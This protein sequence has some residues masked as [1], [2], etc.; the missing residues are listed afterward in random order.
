MRHQKIKC[1]NQITFLYVRQ[2]SLQAR[3]DFCEQNGREKVRKRKKRQTLKK[4]GKKGKEVQRKQENENM[5]QEIFNME[6]FRS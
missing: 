1:S 3:T 2:P 6:L 5:I 4:E